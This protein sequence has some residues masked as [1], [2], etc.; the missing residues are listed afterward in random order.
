MN[1]AD[2]EDTDISP[3]ETET[4]PRI[5]PLVKSLCLSAWSGDKTPVVR[6][7]KIPARSISEHSE[8]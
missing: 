5:L 4:C 8:Q 6:N 7:T 1:G 3:I 2:A